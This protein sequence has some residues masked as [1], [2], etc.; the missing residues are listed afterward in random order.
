MNKLDINKF[1]NYKKIKTLEV[2][3][4]HKSE[5]NKIL[6]VFDNKSIKN[7]INNI[8]NFIKYDVEGDWLDRINIIINE[9]KNDSSS[10][11]SFKVRY[12]E[13]EA[14]RLFN[15]KNKK[16]VISN[17]KHFIYGK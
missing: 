3:D 7:R 14:L 12:G 13:N 16:Q 17:C 8:V 2:N 11:E 1:L 4:R 15:K 9:L 5:I 10:L 6:T